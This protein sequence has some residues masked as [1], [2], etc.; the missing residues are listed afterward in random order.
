MEGTVVTYVLVGSHS[1]PVIAYVTE[2]ERALVH[3][4]VSTQLSVE[5]KR[6]FFRSANTNLGA[7]ALCLSGVY[8]RLLGGNDTESRAGGA[9]FGYYHFGVVR[10]FLDAKMLPRVIAGTSAGG[11]I[12]ALICTHTDEELKALLVPRLADKITACEDSITVWITRFLRTGARFD[13]VEWA[14]KVLCA[15]FLVGERFLCI[16]A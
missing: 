8:S 10:A 2:V 3:V 9:S 11:L 12:A 13:S 15:T 16:V 1:H 7:S 6:K 14:K 4:R 5:E